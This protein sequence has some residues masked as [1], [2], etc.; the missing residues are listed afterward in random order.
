MGSTSKTL[1]KMADEKF[2]PWNLVFGE[3]N[4]FVRWWTGKVPSKTI[5]KSEIPAIKA[6]HQNDI[7]DFGVIDPLY[8]PEYNALLERQDALKFKGVSP[9]PLNCFEPTMNACSELEQNAM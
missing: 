3:K 9:E 2:D 5:P 8:K 1:L 7:F 6:Q 4:P